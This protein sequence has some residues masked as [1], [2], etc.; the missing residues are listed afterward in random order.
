MI[1]AHVNENE[2]YTI[3]CI[4]CLI[5][6]LTNKQFD[7]D[8]FSVSCFL[9]W[10]FWRRAHVQANDRVHWIWCASSV[11]LLSSL[12]NVRI[13]TPHQTAL[14]QAWVARG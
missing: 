7:A 9:Q 11:T 2:Y 10:I 5:D 4:V 14:R 6:R 1:I 3:D 8:V 13:R 12:V